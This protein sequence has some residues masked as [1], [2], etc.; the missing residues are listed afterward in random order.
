MAPRK[1]VQPSPVAPE[2]PVPPPG[3]PVRVLPFD[4][5]FLYTVLANGDL[6]LNQ[7]LP[8]KPKPVARKRTASDA[9][10]ALM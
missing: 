6:V 4:W 5:P 2:L 7:R 8:V 10:D 1:K 9:D 3:M